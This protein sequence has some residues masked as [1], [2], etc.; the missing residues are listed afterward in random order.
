MKLW[1]VVLLTTINAYDPF[2][3]APRPTEES[4]P[5][6]NTKL[7]AIGGDDRSESGAPEV[8]NFG[9]ANERSGGLLPLGLE[10]KMPTKRGEINKQRILGESR[11]VNGT[12]AGINWPFI[13][14]LKVDG[15][16]QCGGSILNE[17][18]ILTAA[19]CLNRMKFVMI[20]L[21]DLH[22]TDIEPGEI[23]LISTDFFIHPDFDQIKMTNDIALIRLPKSIQFNDRM[24]PVCL[25]QRPPIVMDC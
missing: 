25:A 14:R 22:R 12:E 4:S 7:V 13:V 9:V 2:G 6:D 8:K 19:H 24:Q 11:I 5:A 20:T 16:Y 23:N 15:L 21:G 18:W 17:E 1:Q 3:F 10:C